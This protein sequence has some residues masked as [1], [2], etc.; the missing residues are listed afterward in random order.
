MKSLKVIKYNV[1]KK[2]SALLLLTISATALSGCGH[3]HT[4]ANKWSSNSEEHWQD[5]TCEHAGQVVANR[6]KHSDLNHDDICDVC[7]RELTEPGHVH[8]FS[9]D[10]SSDQNEHWHAATCGHNV[11]SDNQNHFD[12]DLDGFCDICHYEMGSVDPLRI[13]SIEIK[14]SLRKTSYSWT[15]PWDLSGLYVLAT[16]VSNTQRQLDSNEYDWKY[17]AKEPK[18][19]VAS[20]VL[21]A[22]YKKDTS[23]SATRSFTGLKVEDE[24]YDEASEISQY[25]SSCN[26]T[27]TGSSL[28]NELHRH[29]FS[30]H[31]TFVK[32]S[33]TQSYLGKG[34]GFEA[35]D[36]IPNKHKTEMF[37]TG[38]EANYTI[39]SREHVWPCND[40]GGLW[41]RGKV[42]DSSYYGGGSDLYH[43]RPCNS[44]VN[45]ARGDAPYIDFDDSEFSKYKS[46]VIE[47]GDNGPYKLK[48]YGTNSE[49]EFASLVEPAD[50]FKGDI[51][52]IVAYIYMH[53]SDI[54]TTPSKYSSLVGSLDLTKVIGYST[55]SKAKAKLKE[56][57]DLDPVSEVEKRRNHTVQQIQGNRNPFVDYPDLLESA[58]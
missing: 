44:K 5:A 30:K 18:N 55:V 49:G 36:L 11:T 31:T 3:Q 52:R 57:N 22:T 38:S 6:A 9:A 19:L 13:K 2:F 56:W 12:N 15:D 43:V 37:Y 48:T 7:G 28:M 1:M 27:L 40:S 54:G 21:T 47:F 32:Y 42:D 46:S 53:Y 51:A 8:T 23:I 35:P 16:T 17:N 14:G 41:P 34:K 58:F 4:W 10:W 29:S 50:E 26:L 33:E 20:L 45:T 39:G 25:Y 24:I